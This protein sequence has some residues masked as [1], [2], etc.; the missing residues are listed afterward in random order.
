MADQ[1][2]EVVCL[3]PPCQLFEVG[4]SRPNQLWNHFASKTVE[5]AGRSL[6]E[7]DMRTDDLQSS[8]SS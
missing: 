8:P 7:L 6:V 2:E 5:W 1:M 4:P 3:E